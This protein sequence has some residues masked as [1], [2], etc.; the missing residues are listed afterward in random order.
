MPP[1]LLLL[2]PFWPMIWRGLA[3]IAVIFAVWWA[4]GHYVKDPY[5]AQGVA[6]EHVKTVAAEARAE[7]AEGANKQF[8]ADLAA[9][10]TKYEVQRAKMAELSRKTVAAV[11]AAQAAQAQLTE[12]QAESRGEIDR[13]RAIAVEPLPV[14]KEVDCEETRVLAADYAARRLRIHRPVTD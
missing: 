6:M 7:A 13:L 8:E 9:L 14:T 1:F 2:K 4:W 12:Q 5:I 10:N 11:A 3:V